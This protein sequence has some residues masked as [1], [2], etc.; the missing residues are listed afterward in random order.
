MKSK[1]SKVWWSRNSNKSA[2]LTNGTSHWKRHSGSLR[3]LFKDGRKVIPP[4][5]RYNHDRYR[6]YFTYFK[7]EREIRGDDLSLKK[8]FTHFLGHSHLRSV[9][10]WAEIR[11]AGSWW[12]L[13]NVCDRSI[14]QLFPD[15]SADVPILGHISSQRLCCQYRTIVIQFST[16]RTCC[17]A[18]RCRSSRAP[19][20]S[21]SPCPPISVVTCS[22]TSDLIRR[23]TGNSIFF[24]LFIGK[25]PDDFCRSI[26]DGR[27]N[28]DCW[29]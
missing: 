17:E 25:P 7:Y 22:R 19:I 18:N 9:C 12:R 10:Q 24:E 27:I 14:S 21:D 8:E 3:N 26:P 4:P 5:K 16:F 20:C 6:F 13:C 1:V 29:K 23:I 11:S 2:R 15:F 28:R